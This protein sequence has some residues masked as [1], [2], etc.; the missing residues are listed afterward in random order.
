MFPS[1]YIYNLCS[2]F[3]L[4][5]LPIVVIRF[6]NI[7]SLQLEKKIWEQ[8]VVSIYLLGFNAS[9]KWENT[10]CVFHIHSLYVCIWFI[11]SFH[12]NKALSFTVANCQHPNLSLLQLK[13][14]I[15]KLLL[16]VWDPLLTCLLNKGSI[17]ETDNLVN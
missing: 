14:A 9:L 4:F 2:F 1:L 3:P 13:L 15:V 5:Y 16:Q 17:N 11:S 12:W 6:E 7:G 8:T 10:S